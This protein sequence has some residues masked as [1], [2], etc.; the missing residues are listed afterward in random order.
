LH[1]E[2]YITKTK[3]LFL[4]FIYNYVYLYPIYNPIG[5]VRVLEEARNLHSGDVKA[6]FR[7]A[8]SNLDA[9]KTVELEPKRS[10]SVGE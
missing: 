7:I 1:C 3:V 9:L 5:G 6:I 4:A 10:F 2:G 8:E